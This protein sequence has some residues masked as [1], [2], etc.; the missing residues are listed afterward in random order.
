MNKKSARFIAI[1]LL[2]AL[3]MMSTAQAA[4]FCVT[5][6]GQL[7]SVLNVADSNAQDDEIRIEEGSYTVP[8]G[9]SFIYSGG[10]SAG[11][12]S[13][14]VISGG[15]TTFGGN[16]CGRQL[17]NANA[18]ATLLDGDDRERVL[19]IVAGNQTNITISGISF[20]SGNPSGASIGGALY[21]R[22]NG[23]VSSGTVLIER[24]VFL[25]STAEVASAVRISDSTTTRFIGN[26]VVGNNTF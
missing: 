25:S 13:D 20:T 12:D 21:I 8:Q 3:G 24:S 16:P 10:S 9:G 7:Q 22:T 19:E 23:S 2:F 6:A 11:D 15:W 5:T 14:L 4:V 26:L 1:T 17:S 18:F